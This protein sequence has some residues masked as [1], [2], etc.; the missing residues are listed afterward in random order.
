[1]RLPEIRQV[2]FETA[3]RTYLEEAW[4]PERI[5]ERWPTEALIGETAEAIVD[6]FEDET[7]R[8]G[9][10]GLR[11]HVLRLGNPDYPHMK[12]VLQEVLIPGEFFF[13]VDTHDQ[14]ELDSSLPGFD[15]W[16]AIKVSNMG[17]KGAIETRWREDPSVPTTA[18]LLRMIAAP[19]PDR[20]VTRVLVVDDEVEIAD[21]VAAVL[22]HEGY[23]VRQAYDGRQA[24]AAVEEFS[25]ELLVMDYQMPG[26]D[27]VEVCRELRGCEK[28][29]DIPIVLATASMTDLT[30][31]GTL[32]NG[33]L[34]KP[35]NR[36]FLVGFVRRLVPPRILADEGN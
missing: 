6:N 33:F 14:M 35:Y 5:E 30:V 13:S 9:E 23:S 26:L 19:D 28:T 34:M 8:R 18:D 2:T 12:L 1:V 16:M 11:R 17:L 29:R 7:R 36:E 27:G 4:G 21:V 24:L 3:V 15:A 31:F 32:A 22:A 25:P 20:G 10:E